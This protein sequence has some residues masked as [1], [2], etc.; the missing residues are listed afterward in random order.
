[1]AACTRYFTIDIRLHPLR[2]T[3]HSQYANEAESG[4]LALRL[5][6]SALQGF[7]R[8]LLQFNTLAR[9]P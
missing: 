6:S 5:A 1:M 8:G 2:R 7:V 3:G 9:L 4:S